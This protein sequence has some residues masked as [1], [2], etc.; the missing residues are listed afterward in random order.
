MQAGSGPG[1][2]QSVTA[3]QDGPRGS[4]DSGRDSWRHMAQRVPEIPRGE[5]WLRS[6]GLVFTPCV[7]TRCVVRAWRAKGQGQPARDFCVPR[8]LATG[9]CDEASGRCGLCGLGRQAANSSDLI[10]FPALSDGICAGQ[11]R[12]R[13]GASLAPVRV[14]SIQASPATPI[15]GRGHFLLTV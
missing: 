13:V 15:G 14:P 3:R 11:G 7:F 9:A 5:R 8:L 2:A 10:R 12:V 4:T 6:F 1:H